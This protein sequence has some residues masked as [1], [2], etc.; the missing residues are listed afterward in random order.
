MNDTSPAPLPRIK[1]FPPSQL[2]LT[3]KEIEAA[4]PLYNELRRHQAYFKA[5]I[6]RKGHI[7]RL[8][9]FVATNPLDEWM[10]VTDVPMQH[11]R[12]LE[13]QGLIATIKVEDRFY[14]RPAS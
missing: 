11:L 4:R 2:D 7:N 13:R 9:D 1:E 8:R 6:H 10:D 5:A 14:S 12:C 3:I